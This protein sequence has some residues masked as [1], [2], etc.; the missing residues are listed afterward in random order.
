VQHGFRYARSVGIYLRG[1]RD[2]DA[3]TWRIEAAAKAL[4]DKGFQVTVDVDDQWRPASER[5]Q[6]A[7]ERA[8][9]RAERYDDRADAAAGRRDARH[10]AA[11][12]VLDMIPG[13]QPMMPGHHSY[14]GDRS[15]RERALTNLDKAI[16]EDKYASRLADRADAVRAHAQRKEHPRVVMRRIE[17]LQADLRRWERELNE[18]TSVDTASDAYQ[19]RVQREIDRLTEDIA[20]QQ[21]KLDQHAADGTFVAWGP[22]TL[23]K[24]DLVRGEFG[25]Y[26]VTRIN[27]K[28]VSLDRTDWPQRLTF[29]RVYGRRR[30]GMQLDTPAGKP[31]PVELALQ[32]ARWQQAERR[33]TNP[34]YD[35]DAQRQ[36]R[37]V[38][39]ARRLVHGLDLSAHDRQVAAFWPTGKTPEALAERRRL[40][41]AYLAVYDRLE[42]DERVPDII[43]TLTPERDGAGWVMPDGEP[44]DRKPQQLKRGDIIA[45]LWDTGQRGRELWPHF[46]GP[47]EQVSDPVAHDGRSWVVVT[48]SDGAERELAVT[49]WLAVHPAA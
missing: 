25:W 37:Y 12:Q 4:R 23:V 15:R 41:A 30:D 31:S 13:G 3:Q 29:D 49:G 26:P 48:L 8:D 18:A 16:D 11:H 5:E 2:R 39:Y 45:G 17:T 24:G 35:Q 33:A 21:A 7:A 46:Q 20:H 34:G 10:D 9:E 43:A 1:S 44:V 28:S 40:S 42:A 6:A 36:A 32:V 14:H 38:G 22:Q 47:V 19:A 27:T